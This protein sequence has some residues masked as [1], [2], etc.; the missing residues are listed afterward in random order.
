MINAELLQKYLSL[1]GQEKMLEMWF[2]FYEETKA[3]MQHSVNEWLEAGS[4]DL[5]R[6]FFHSRRS[7]ALV[8]GMEAFA[9]ACAKR[10]NFL[11][12]G[13]DI[14]IVKSEQSEINTL[15]E[16]EASA[17]VNYLKGSIND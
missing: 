15:F 11:V 13:G 5:L 3:D 1:L 17:V 9:E 6:N 8:Y 14:N 7:G 16:E 2:P 12:D 4:R 10:E